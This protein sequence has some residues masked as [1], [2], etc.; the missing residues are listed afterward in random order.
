MPIGN[1]AASIGLA[2][3][4]FGELLIGNFV[5]SIE[6]AALTWEP[7]FCQQAKGVDSKGNSAPRALSSATGAG[8]LIQIAP[9]TNYVRGQGLPWAR[10][11]ATK[12]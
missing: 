11:G 1:S 12:V 9:T 8:V 3:L 5:G 4:I 2:A 7:P 6:L 10:Q